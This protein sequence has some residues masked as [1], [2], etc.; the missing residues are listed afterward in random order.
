MINFAYPEYLYALFAIPVIAALYI[1]ARLSR[2]I[3]LK[4]FGNHYNT[5]ELMP[6]AS[7]YLPNIKMV[8]ELCALALIIFAIARP[9]VKTDS[10]VDLTPEESTVKGIE[11]M[12]CVDVSN[13]MLA[14]ANNDINGRSR[15][16]RAKMILDRAL[17]KM[18]NDRVGLIVF[19]GNA[20]LQL[21]ITPDISSAKM[22]VNMLNTEMV[23]FQGTAIGSAIDMAIDAFNPDSDLNK[24][25]VVI[26]DGENFEDDAIEAA[27]DAAKVNIQ[28]NVIGMGGSDKMP[29]PLPGG[30]YMQYNGQEVRTGLDAEG[31]AEIASVGNGIY[32]SG[33][34]SN[35]ADELDVQLEKIE[36]KEYSRSSIPSDSTD[37]FPLFASLAILLL[38]IDIFLPYSKLKW[39][40]NIRFFS[41]KPKQR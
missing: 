36:A 27:G 9:Y 11:V 2:R 21:P 23:P 25:I 12:F 7:R 6:D 26:T 20:Y 19:A 37:L 16:D 32:I 13:S 28:V 35:V 1:L 40:K 5:E 18:E 17:D 22:F 14:S 4:R 34:D 29:I 10:D 39:L 15:L 8:I 24:S 31:A 30:G 33:N 41:T 3:K 38:L